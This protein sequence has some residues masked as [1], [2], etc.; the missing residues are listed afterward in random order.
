MTPSRPVRFVGALLAGA[1]LVLSTAGACGGDEAPEHPPGH[2][3]PP[4]DGVPNDGDGDA[5]G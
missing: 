2:Q 5:D 3:V 4:G 1:A